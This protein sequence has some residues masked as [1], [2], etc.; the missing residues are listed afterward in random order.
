MQR[1]GYYTKAYHNRNYDFYDRNLTH[2]NLGYNKY[3]GT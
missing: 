3:L 2:E 1:L